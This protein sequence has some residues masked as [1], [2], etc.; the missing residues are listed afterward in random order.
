MSTPD[1]KYAETIQ[2]RIRVMKVN[3][4]ERH[5]DA[6]DID[7]GVP[8]CLDAQSGLDLDKIKKAKI[9]HAT[10]KVFIAELS[11]DLERQLTELSMED[12]KLRH[13]LQIMKQSGSKFKKFELITIK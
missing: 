1:W 3:Y 5:L 7:E 8:F 9:Y 13:N 6:Q 12:T 11:G 4:Q 10:I 2:R